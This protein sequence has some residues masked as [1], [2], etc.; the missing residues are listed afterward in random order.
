MKFFL[1]FHLFYW[2]LRSRE[3]LPHEASSQVSSFQ[4]STIWSSY[5]LHLI[6]SS[7][8]E[9]ST[10]LRCLKFH[11]FSLV[12]LSPSLC[13]LV[14]DPASAPRRLKHNISFSLELSN[15]MCVTSP[16]LFSFIFY[17]CASLR[18]LPSPSIITLTRRRAMVRLLRWHSEIEAR[19]NTRKHRIHGD[20]KE[21]L[22]LCCRWNGWE[23][24][25][26]SSK[27]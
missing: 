27:K 1:S 23:L 10:F 17:P 5:L 3:N 14:R 15:A 6:C 26:S 9:L 20:Q 24:D 4:H 2:Q 8:F 13:W 11:N 22:K 7:V 25:S 16:M 21:T 12:F 18:W 19:L